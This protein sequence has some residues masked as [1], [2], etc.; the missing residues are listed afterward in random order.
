MSKVKL[1]YLTRQGQ[2]NDQYI[3]DFGQ[4]H[5]ICGGVE[6]VLLVPNHPPIYGQK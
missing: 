3:P 6:L 2:T 4:A 5:K 1:K